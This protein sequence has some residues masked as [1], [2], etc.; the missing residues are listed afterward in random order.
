MK[1]I[2]EISE[3]T[4]LKLSLKAVIKGVSLKKYIELILLSHAE[5]NKK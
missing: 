4:K 2:I 1:K 5:S 3:D